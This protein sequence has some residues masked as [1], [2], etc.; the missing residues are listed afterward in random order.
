MGNGLAGRA[1]R[2]IVASAGAVAALLTLASSAGA[3]VTPRVLGANVLSGL[4]GLASAAADPRAPMTVGVALQRPDPAGEASLYAQLYQPGGPGYRHFLTPSQ[5][6][7]RFAPAA[8]TFAAA[9]G[10]LQAAGLSVDTSSGSRDYILASGTVSQVQNAFSTTIR[11]FTSAGT[12]FLANTTPPQVPGDLPILS[13]VGLNTYQRFSTPATAAGPTRG[14]LSLT[15]LPNIGA[16][17]PQTL[18]SVYDQ[19]NA[20]RGHGQSIAVFGEGASAGTISDLAQFEHA[21]GL[22]S[23]PVTVRDIGP[24]PFS[25]TSGAEE[26]DIDTQASTGM[27]P[28][29]KGLTLYFGDTLVD[30]TVEDLFTTW[31]NDPNGPA[32]ANASFGECERTPLD[33]VFLSLPGDISQDPTATLGLA[34]GN[35]L[36]PVAEQTLRQAAIEG[37]TLFSASG[38]TGSSC[39]VIV[40]PTVGA[41][42]GILNQ[43]VPLTSYPAS[44]PYA[45]AVGGTVLYTNATTPASRALEY[46]W[47]F[48]GG[49]DSLLINAPAYQQGT[50]GL[51][52]PCVAT[53]DGQ[54]TNLGATC[55][56]VPDVAAQSGDVLTNGYAIVS[57]GAATQGGGTSLSSPLWAGMWARVNQSA[58]GPGYGFANETLYRLGKNA[59][60]AARDFFDVT[61]GANGL[62][63]ALPGWD[64]VSGFGTPNVANIIADAP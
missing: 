58:G 53:P 26:W 2:R 27:A 56:G 34:L 38:D 16:S 43:V 9:T 52:L 49:G 15:G 41:G 21:N 18:W 40:L 57:G 50:P 62:Y 7:D 12:S 1:A 6:N 59:T 19:P 28:D 8:A 36:E 45:V 3:Q 17:T 13:V 10:W 61:L 33:P 35:N 39:P 51:F 25:D 23:V 4:S 54:L 48:T 47:T 5:F 30:A 37:R 46:A 42:N 29:V 22:P 32:Q 24:G 55:R 63:A 31:V 64:Y 44:S 60:T 11:R 20:Y 14:L